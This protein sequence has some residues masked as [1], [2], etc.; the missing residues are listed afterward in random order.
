MVQARYV[1][2]N[3]LCIQSRAGCAPGSGLNSP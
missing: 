1:G 3:R 2:M